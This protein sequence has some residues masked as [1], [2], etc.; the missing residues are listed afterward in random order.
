MPKASTKPKPV[1]EAEWESPREAAERSGVSRQTVYNWMDS[2][3][4]EARKMGSRTLI[5]VASRR[6]YLDNLP[7]VQQIALPKPRGDGD[8]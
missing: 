3:L 4:I 2:G 6:A 1:I 8:A 7:T 5:R